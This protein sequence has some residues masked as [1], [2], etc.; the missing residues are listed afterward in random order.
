MFS[1]E[2]QVAYYNRKF[3]I[4]FLLETNEFRISRF[5][6]VLH[7]QGTGRKICTCPTIYCEIINIAKRLILADFKDAKIANLNNRICITSIRLIKKTSPNFVQFKW[8]LYDL[9]IQIYDSIIQTI[10]ETFTLDNREVWI[11]KGR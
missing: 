3:K 8:C 11:N 2:T 7:R 10:W 6:T 5:K 1:H 4:W 9:T